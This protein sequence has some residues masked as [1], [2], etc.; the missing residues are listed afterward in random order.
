MGNRRRAREMAMQALYYIDLSRRRPEEALALFR[1]TFSPSKKV[2][3]FF[4]ELVEGVL[5]DKRLLDGV[6]ETYSD[7]WRVS[8]MACVDRNVIR[9][10]VY[11]MLRHPDIPPKVSINEA[12]D[13][14]KKFGTEESGPF[15]NGILD[16]MRLA[17]EQGRIEPLPPPPPPDAG[18][19][20]F[21]SEG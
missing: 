10:A 3:P 2:E 17:L 5:R 13:I 12:I 9:I 15:I 6:I 20:D 1:K 16:G 19:A 7:N 21:R 14:G 8:R 11:E 4:A 18:E